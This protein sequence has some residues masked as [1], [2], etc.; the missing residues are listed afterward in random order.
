MAKKK[1]DDDTTNKIMW[2]AGTAAVTAFAMYY[3]NRH[4]N[5]REELSRLRYA[6]GRKRLESSGGGEG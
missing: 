4:L 2:V 1:N 6:E 5:E 3:V